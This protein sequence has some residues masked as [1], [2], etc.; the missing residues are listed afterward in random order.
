V[1]AFV[2]DLTDTHR[3]EFERGRI[4]AEARKLR[5]GAEV[6]GRL[7]LSTGVLQDLPALLN[8]VCNEA[9][10]FLGVD[11]AYI[12]LLQNDRLEYAASHGLPGEILPSLQIPLSHYGHFN[13]KVFREKRMLFWNDP[14]DDRII[15]DDVLRDLLQ[16]RS[17]L[18]TPLLV[19][20]KA[21]GVLTLIDSREPRTFTGNEMEFIMQ[22]GNHAAIV[23][24]NI[25]LFENLRVANKDLV[26]AYDTT[27][28]GWAKALELRDRETEGHTQRVAKLTLELARKLGMSEEE[29]T[30]VYRGAI[31]HDI[32]KMGVPDSILSKP[33]SLNDTEWE[34][35]RRHPTYAYEMLKPIEYLRPALDIP[36]CHHEKWDGSGYPRGLKGEEIPPTARI[37]AVVDVW[38]A[39]TS[40]RPYREA[41]GDERTLNYIRAEKGSHFDP[42]VVENFIEIVHSQGT[43]DQ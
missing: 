7:M 26:Q 39:L 41:W 32:G 28:A 4:E 21:I 6:L 40:T 2:R 22:L 25:R 11:S 33:G 30:H 31:L 34:I 37:F 38:D 17:I 9:A 36:Y 8:L 13:V 35:M 24:E 3:W 23:V 10:A 43:S 29:L 14:H 5:M 19:S 12:C 15:M 20:G 18:A 42:Q 16:V 27:L 1:I